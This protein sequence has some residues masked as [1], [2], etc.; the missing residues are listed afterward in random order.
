[1]LGTTRRCGESEPSRAIAHA[2]WGVQFFS[3][4]EVVEY[5][6]R[7]FKGFGDIPEDRWRHIATTSVFTCRELQQSMRQGDLGR[8]A[9]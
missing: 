1:M 9:G 7:T 8:L 4:D 5:C 2:L 6:K 3:I